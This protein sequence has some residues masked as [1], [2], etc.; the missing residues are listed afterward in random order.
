MREATADDIKAVLSSP[1]VRERV[2]H[3]EGE[4]LVPAYMVNERML[5]MV[6]Q[7]TPNDVE[8]HV[9]SARENW[10]HLR[11]DVMELVEALKEAGYRNIYTGISNEYRRTQNLARKCGFAPIYYS[12]NEVIFR[13]Q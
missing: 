4:P 6:I 2:P 13:W 5:G 3:A 11:D 8:M 12:G 7:R 10:S 1:G 9:L